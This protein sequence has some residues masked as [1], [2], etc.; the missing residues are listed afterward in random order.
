MPDLELQPPP[1]D[2]LPAAKPQAKARSGN[3]EWYTDAVWID[4]ARRVMGG[5]DL[6]PASSAVAQRTVRAGTF[7]TAEDDGLSRAWFGKVWLNPPYSQPLIGQ[8]TDRVVLEYQRGNVEA[9]VVLVPLGWDTEWGQRL[10]AASDAICF[11][12]GRLKFTSGVTGERGPS[13]NGSLVCYLGR[14]AETFTDVFA[15]CG[16]V[17]GQALNSA[18]P[19]GLQQ[20]MEVG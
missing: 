16:V 20:G 15:D 13:P 14:A 2:V 6:D 17:F 7:Y 8:F 9:A 5:V 18:Y 3:D 10:L 19:P 11:A 12:G 1:P 4:R